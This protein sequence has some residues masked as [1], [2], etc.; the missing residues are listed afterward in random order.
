MRFILKYYKN[1]VLILTYQLEITRSYHSRN[2]VL[3][4]NHTVVLGAGLLICSLKYLFH[5]CKRPV[6]RSYEIV[7]KCLLVVNEILLI[8]GHTPDGIVVHQLNVAENSKAL[9]VYGY[10]IHSVGKPPGLFK[11]EII[12]EILGGKICA[13]LHERELEIT[14]VVHCVILEV[15]RGGKRSY[16]ALYRCVSHNDILELDVQLFFYKAVSCEDCRINRIGG[17]LGNNG[18]DC[19]VTLVVEELEGISLIAACGK[20]LKE[21]SI[22]IINAAL[23]NG[24]NGSSGRIIS[25]ILTGREKCY[26]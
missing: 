22:L 3:V 17:R 18:C 24:G 19:V 25:L 4:G 15:V 14:L 16:S 5:L 12:F 9:T 8:E 6:A 1:I 20:I 11:V 13:A 21:L 26:S 10:T 7:G 23:R 2:E